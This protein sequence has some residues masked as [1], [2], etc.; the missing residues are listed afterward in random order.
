MSTKDEKKD[1]KQKGNGGAAAKPIEALTTEEVFSRLKAVGGLLLV[2]T[3]ADELSAMVKAEVDA[4]IAAEKERAEKMKKYFVALGGEPPLDDAE[5]GAAKRKRATRPAPT[6]D[7]EIV[8]VAI[9][10][11]REKNAKGKPPKGRGVARATGHDAAKVEA[12][13]QGH[14]D[15]FKGDDKRWHVRKPIQPSA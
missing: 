12:L 1:E 8:E 7:A 6:T 13:L 5:Q 14:A 10:Y 3:V 11:I 15:V 4:E 2:K 9:S